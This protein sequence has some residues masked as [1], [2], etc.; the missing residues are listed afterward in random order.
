MQ[1]NIGTITMV[2]VGDLKPNPR[3]PNQHNDD[4][5]ERLSKAIVQQGWRNPIVVSNQTGFIV[6]GHGR[7]KASQ[8]LGLAQVPVSYQN[9]EN[10]A[11][12]NAHMLADN[13]LGE[14]AEMDNASLK[15]LLQE[16]DTG[17][18]DLELTGYKQ[19]EIESLMTQIFQGDDTGNDPE[20][21]LEIMK[22]ND[23]RQIMLVMDQAQFEETID[24]LEKLKNHTGLESNTDVIISLIKKE[25]DGI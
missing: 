23:L 15:D 19:N 22:G 20:A 25:M 12:E 14:L 16:L 3:N 24:A 9:F 1:N 18:I 6:A 17:E 21:K 10:E 2:P 7:F 4:Q 13:R 11:Q 8:K 5:L